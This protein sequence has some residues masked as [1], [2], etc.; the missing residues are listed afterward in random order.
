MYAVFFAVKNEKGGS[1]KPI[2]PDYMK[3]TSKQEI[4]TMCVLC[5][6]EAV[7][8]NLRIR[9]WLLGTREC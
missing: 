2:V 4:D 6:I 1:R 3:S 5:Y 9:S 8:K 7:I